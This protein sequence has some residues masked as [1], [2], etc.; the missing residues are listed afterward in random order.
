MVNF[1]EPNFLASGGILFA[2]DKSTI[3][4]KLV[5]MALMMGSIVSWS[6]IISKTRQLDLARRQTARFLKKFRSSRKPL[7]IFLTRET[8]SQSPA[9]AVYVHG[10]RELSYHLVGS[11]E[12]DETSAARLA[13]AERIPPTAMAGVESAIASE[14]GQQALRLEERM[15]FLAMAVSGAPFLGLLGTVWGVMDAFSDVAQAGKASLA[16]LAPGV[17][18]ALIT[19]V[20]GLLVAIPAMFFYNYLV[21]SVRGLIVELDNFAAELA[22]S[23]SHRFVEG[24]RELTR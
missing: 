11:S 2:F 5:I 1:L 22:A 14:V 7:Q 20:T 19:T 23:F 4:G 10:C 21:G 6:V 24:S 13:Q 12:I 18:G 9:Y 15:V 8:F 3:A 17:S 16:T